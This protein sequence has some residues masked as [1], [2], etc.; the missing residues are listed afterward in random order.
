MTIDS[1]PALVR[2]GE[3][4]VPFMVRRNIRARRLLLRVETGTGT[5]VLTLPK[6]A[7]LAEG[8]RFVQAN[9][10]WAI[11]RLERMPA[12]L[13]FADGASVPIRGL[14]HVIRHQ[15]GVRGTAWIEDGELRVA[16]RPEHVGRRVRDFLVRTARDEFAARARDLAARVGRATGRISIR[17]GK[18]RW[19]S[20]ASNGNLAFSWRILMA[21]EHVIDYLIAHEVAHLR[22]M[23]HGPAFW[24]L[25]GELA[26]NV[27]GAKRWLRRHGAELHRYGP[28]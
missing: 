9:A 28:T 14:A 1:A 16:G 7:S 26:R 21:P 25:V 19:G 6:R 5:V 18:S 15:P 10:G 12:A 27:E 13:A 17:D 20:C 23:N 2:L 11:A 4:D 22:H 8:M 24:A 3:R